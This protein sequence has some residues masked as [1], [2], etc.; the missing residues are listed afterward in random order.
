MKLIIHIVVYNLSNKMRFIPALII[1]SILFSLPSFSPAN[2]AYRPDDYAL[3]MKL[4][5]Y[6]SDGTERWNIEVGS[7]LPVKTIVDNH[8]DTYIL[9]QNADPFKSDRTRILLIKYDTNGQELWSKDFNEN[10]SQAPNDFV[11]DNSN[12]VYVAGRIYNATDNLYYGFITIKYDAQGSLIWKSRF[13][14]HNIFFDN[15]SDVPEA[16]TVDSNQN[17]YVTGWSGHGFASGIKMSTVKYEPAGQQEWA[18]TYKLGKRNKAQAIALD[19]EENIYVA[20]VSTADTLSEETDRILIKYDAKGNELWTAAYRIHEN[21]NFFRGYPRVFLDIDQNDNVYMAGGFGCL[22]GYKHAD[23]LVNKYDSEGGSLWTATYSHSDEGSDSV[24]GM[25]LDDQ[26]NAIVTG[27]SERVFTEFDEDVDFVTVKF[28]T[29][30]NLLWEARFDQKPVDQPSSLF[31]DA[32]GNIFV[33]G[34]SCLL[35]DSGYSDWENEFCDYT[36][37]QYDKDGNE[38]WVAGFDG[39]LNDFADS[40]SVGINSIVDNRTDT[41]KHALVAGRTWKYTGTGDDDDDNNDN[42]DDDLTDDDDDSNDGLQS[43]DDN[44]S[45]NEN[46]KSCCS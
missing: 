22:Q 8:A 12:N 26:D 14:T 34:C 39:G 40:V 21:C 23:F 7:F 9:G 36:T 18:A 4:I 46:D 20:G 37:I 44:D 45:D 15:I 41:E 42:T 5:D 28:D 43:D 27:W 24:I 38:I 2:D 29:D 17:V 3:Y 16:I 1:L 6:N 31:V 35:Y 25:A 10:Y 13:D 19:Q 32:S 33:T 11:M 30:G